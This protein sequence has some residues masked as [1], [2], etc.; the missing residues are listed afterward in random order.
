MTEP[1]RAEDQDVERGAAEENADAP[2]DDME[3]E[4]SRPPEE[5]WPEHQG[6]ESESSR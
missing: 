4:V 3:R 6:R 5:R 1:E 2:L